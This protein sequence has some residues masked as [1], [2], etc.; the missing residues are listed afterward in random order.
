MNELYLENFKTL[1]RYLK[2]K[3]KKYIKILRN[4]GKMNTESIMN[5]TEI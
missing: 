3:V 4:T 1:L 5:I 2:G